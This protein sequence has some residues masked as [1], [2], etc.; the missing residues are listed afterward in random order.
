MFHGGLDTQKLMPFGSVDEVKL[1]TRRTIEVLGKG[2]GYFFSPAHRIQAD[3]LI[4]N[5]LAAY[6]V[7]EEYSR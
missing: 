7:V 2:G 4:E 1:A 5:I 3:T 6:E